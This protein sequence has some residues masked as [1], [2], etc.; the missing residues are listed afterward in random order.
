[1]RLRLPAAEPVQAASRA[2][3]EALRL[4]DRAAV[5]DAGTDLLALLS[6]CYEVSQPALSVLGSRPRKVVEGQYTHELFGDYTPGTKKIRVWM[7]TAVL[8][9]VTSHRG[10]L[11]TLLHEFCHHLDIKALGYADSPHT[12]G[13]YGRVDQ[14]YHLALA[15]PTADRRALAWVKQGELW[16]IDWRRMRPVRPGLQTATAPARTDAPL[17]A[18]YPRA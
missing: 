4:D 10:L 9:K 6:A 2:M 15:T 1:M 7:R 5:R 8:G 12:R 18:P 14:L 17:R 13:F 3:A 16:R 11:N